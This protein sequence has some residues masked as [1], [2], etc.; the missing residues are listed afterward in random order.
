MDTSRVEELTKSGV[1][2]Q[3]NWQGQPSRGWG[4]V[5]RMVWP[6][7]LAGHKSSVCIGG[8]VLASLF[9]GRHGPLPVS[10]WI[11]RHSSSCRKRFGNGSRLSVGRVSAAAVTVLSVYLYHRRSLDIVLTS[12]RADMQIGI[13]IIAGIGLWMASETSRSPVRISCFTLTRTP[14][15]TYRLRLRTSFLTQWILPM[16]TV[17]T[18]L[19]WS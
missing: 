16:R 8:S 5:S 3:T 17:F 10:T 4:T 9:G 1:R 6:V 15:F 12:D 2:F 14:S 7:G 18:C 11:M 13:S 19:W